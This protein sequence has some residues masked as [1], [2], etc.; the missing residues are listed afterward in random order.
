MHGI[1]FEA[2][3]KVCGGCYTNELSALCIGLIFCFLQYI[4]YSADF[5][6]LMGWI[7]TLRLGIS[8]RSLLIRRKR[9]W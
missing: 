4:R 6:D 7:S 9:S 5:T 3:C 1:E 2:G 8:T